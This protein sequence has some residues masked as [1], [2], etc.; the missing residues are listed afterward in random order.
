[1]LFMSAFAYAHHDMSS[2]DT[3]SPITLPGTVTNVEW[4]NPH[5]LVQMDVRDAGGKIE[6]WLVQSGSPNV[7]LRRGVTVQTLKPG[8]LLAVAGYP[9]KTGV[10]LGITSGADLIRSGHMVYSY[11]V[12][13]V[14]RNVANPTDTA[15]APR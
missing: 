8:V 11:D 10:T 4:I 2:F 14:G 12:N 9:P 7:M 13:L 6:A 3:S 15:G 1:M 5:V